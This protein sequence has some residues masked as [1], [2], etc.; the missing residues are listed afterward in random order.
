MMTAEA[1]KFERCYREYR[2]G[3]LRIATSLETQPNARRLT[4]VLNGYC[5]RGAARPPV[6]VSWP[7]PS[8]TFGNI[9]RVSDPTLFMTDWI[10]GSCFLGT[11]SANPILAIVK[12]CKMVA[13]E[14]GVS[15]HQMLYLGHSGAGFGALQCAVLDNSA[16]AIGINPVVDIGAYAAYQFAARSAQL[17]RP[18][19]TMTELCAEFPHRLSAA[20]ALKF[21]LAAGKAPRVGLIQNVTD[22]THFRP[23]Y[24]AC[25]EALGLSTSGS[26]DPSGRFHSVTYDK[27]GGHSALPEMS[28]V[29]DMA[30][31]LLAA[32][33]ADRLARKPRDLPNVLSRRSISLYEAQDL[34]DDDR[35]TSGDLPAMFVEPRGVV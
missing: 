7:Q 9:L 29:E 34:T 3:V 2:D 13:G 19:S 20:S 12:I 10:K 11:E 32:R 14:L 35:A 23:H 26:S 1:G 25:C 31:R 15:S 21:A 24:G 22:K 27:R 18:G 30:A 6:F 8:E 16:A 33:R 17:F 5:D 4:V 28:V